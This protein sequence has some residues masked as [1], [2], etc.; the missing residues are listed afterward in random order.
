MKALNLV[1]LILVII[2][3]L[4]LGISGLADVDVLAAIFGGLGA[5]GTRIVFVILGLC[6]LWQ[7]VPL[8]WA[9]GSGEVMAERHIG[10]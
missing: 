6:A 10:A 2:G 1:T 7:I 4:D 8:V 9:F 5:V 3:G